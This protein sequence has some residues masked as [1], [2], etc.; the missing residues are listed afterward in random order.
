MLACISETP[1]DALER[2]VG[3]A[4]TFPCC[5]LAWFGIPCKEWLFP[6]GSAG[7]D[8]S[9]GLS[10]PPVL[11]MD[12]PYQVDVCPAIICLRN[13]T[14]YH[15]TCY[16]GIPPSSFLYLHFTEGNWDP[17]RLSDLLKVTH[18]RSTAET[19]SL[20]SCCRDSVYKHCPSRPIQLLLANTMP[21]KLQ[22]L[23]GKL[24]C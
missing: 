24:K 11:E 22:S 9:Q 17:G 21:V 8:L 6:L 18:R 12:S 16:Q 4:W 15:I 14:S 20:V 10:V 2:T 7:R 5:W 13:F 1:W 3:G 19:C 23:A